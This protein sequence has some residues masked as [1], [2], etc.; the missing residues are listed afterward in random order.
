MEPIDRTPEADKPEGARPPPLAGGSAGGAAA[1]G[2]TSSH[3]SRLELFATRA[4]SDAELERVRQQGRY[5]RFVVV[6]P[7]DTPETP[8]IYAA[9]A[10]GTP[11][12]LI[13]DEGNAMRP[14]LLNTAACFV[15]G[16]CDPKA[17]TLRLAG[18][19]ERSWREMAVRVRVE[20]I[21]PNGFKAPPLRL[22]AVPQVR[23][24]LE[25][26]AE[27]A[28]LLGGLVAHREEALWGAEAF[29][30]RLAAALW[31]LAALRA[32]PA[33]PTQH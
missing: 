12:L 24:L 25:S 13:E 6:P 3:T 2:H 21:F 29:H 5:A 20:D 15:L 14:W 7:G 30:R 18:A 4:P 26:P 16:F 28:A 19:S 11:P 32:A 9:L 1:P 8:R 17:G 31:R 22:S 10:M 33:T 23:R 27:Y